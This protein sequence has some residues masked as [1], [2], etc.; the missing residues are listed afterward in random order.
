MNNHKLFTSVLGISFALYGIFMITRLLKG[1][2][3]SWRT[4]TCILPENAKGFDRLTF[5]VSIIGVFL[6]AALLIS[7]SFNIL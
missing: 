2:G 5:V 7:Y 3:Y 6:S 4:K 1:Y